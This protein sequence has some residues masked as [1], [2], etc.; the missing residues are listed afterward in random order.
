MSDGGEEQGDVSIED[1]PPARDECERHQGIDHQLNLLNS[2]LQGNCLLVHGS[3]WTA[4]AREPNRRHKLL[5]QLSL[6][7]KLRAKLEHA[8]DRAERSL[9]GQARN[10]LLQHTDD[11]STLACLTEAVKGNYVLDSY[12]YYIRKARQEIET[13][14][15]RVEQARAILDEQSE[16]MAREQNETV[17]AN[18]A[19][20]P[21]TVAATITTPTKPPPKTK[22]P[23]AKKASINRAKAP[24]P[25]RPSTR[26]PRHALFTALQSSRV[27]A[28]DPDSTVELSPEKLPKRVGTTK[29]GRRLADSRQCH[30]CKSS[31]T[32]Y[33]QC[34]Y[35]ETDGTQ[36]GKAFCRK[37]I[38]GKYEMTEDDW[39]S[40]TQEDWHCPSCIGICLCLNCAA[41]RRALIA[42]QL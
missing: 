13:Q 1:T 31:T 6:A 12:D 37:C 40:T 5:E 2:R 21:V 4:E 24:P 26:I 14:R 42:N 15:E 36:C 39:D 3:A 35:W 17:E 41:K 16:S 20:R 18:D 25:S 22:K 33:R 7:R 30:Y 9:Q 28:P 38:E 19:T 10:L 23:M 27:A 29:R 11:I 32:Y 34:T 8:A